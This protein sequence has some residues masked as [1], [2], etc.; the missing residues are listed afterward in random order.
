MNDQAEDGMEISKKTATL[1]NRMRGRGPSVGGRRGGRSS[2]GGGYGSASGTEYGI[3]AL[4][5]HL[6]TSTFLSSDSQVLV[7]KKNVKSMRKWGDENPTENDM[8]ALDFSSEMNHSSS[9]PDISA[10]LIDS[11]SLGI[12]RQD[13]TYE[14][15]D[16]SVGEVTTGGTNKEASST[17]PSPLNTFSSLLSRFTRGKELTDQELQPV[18]ARMKEHLMKKNVAKDIAD[19][20]CEGILKS[21]IGK[22]IGGLQSMSGC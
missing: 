4:S 20:V 13:G 17:R 9:N 22:K 15:L 18:I 8:A 6:L 5:L 16:W 12:R 14:I 21:L 1:K 11:Q 19:K 3:I 7:K 2:K 10:G